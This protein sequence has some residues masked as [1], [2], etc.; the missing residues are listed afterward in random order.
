MFTLLIVQFQKKSIP[1]HP[2]EG[3]VPEIPRGREVLEAKILEAKHSMKQN[4]NFWGEG[5]Y[6]TKKPSV[7]GGGG[8]DIFWNCT[9]NR[10]C[11]NVLSV[12]Y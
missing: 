4:W 11:C 2:M 9:L 12:T 1:M 5:G 3:Q 6:K 10:L 8:I 7:G